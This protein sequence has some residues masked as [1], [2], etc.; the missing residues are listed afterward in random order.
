MKSFIGH[1]ILSLVLLL[2][3]CALFDKNQPL[4]KS[5]YGVRSAGTISVTATSGFRK[6]G[7]H[8]VPKGTNLRQFLGMAVILPHYNWGAAETFCGCRVLM[9][10]PDGSREG[11]QSPGKPSEQ[12]LDTVLRDGAAVALM[13]W[14]L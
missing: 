7:I 3:G 8:H 5:A 12:E 1:L 13:K 10:S 14:N 2:T 4:P 11:F 6:P 9:R